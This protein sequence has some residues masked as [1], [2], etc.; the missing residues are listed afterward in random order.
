MLVAANR[1]E[2]YQRPADQARFWPEF[3]HLLAGRD[4]QGCGTWLGVTRCGRFAAV[5][6]YRE[7][8]DPPRSARSRGLPVVEFLAGTETS[9]MEFAGQLAASPQD[10]AGFSL[11]LSDGDHLAYYSNRDA[12]PRLLDPGSYGLSNHLLDTDWPKLS[13][14]KARFV[15]SVENGA[16]MDDLFALLRD[17][18]PVPDQ[19]LPSTGIDRDWERSLSPIFVATE[20][21]GTRCA[22]VIRVHAA[23]LV[24]FEERTFSL[25]ANTALDPGVYRAARFRFPIPS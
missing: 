10:Y 11:L 8:A 3:P 2:F 17:R 5:T 23:G 16:V 9:A 18:T 6:N 20:H 1:D 22:T 13:H 19:I 4:R 14:G 21:Y 12:G 7:P 15:E 25:A 24:E